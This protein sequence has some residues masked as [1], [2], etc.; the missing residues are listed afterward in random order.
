MKNTMFEN[1]TNLVFIRIFNFF[2]LKS[3]LMQSLFHSY[4]SLS[5]FFGQVMHFSKYT[6]VNLMETYLR[7]L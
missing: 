4:Q 2:G 7:P 1:K 5:N 3:I 6:W